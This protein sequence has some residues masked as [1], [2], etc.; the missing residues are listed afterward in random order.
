MICPMCGRKNLEI[1]PVDDYES[2]KMS[3]GHMPVQI[4]APNIRLLRY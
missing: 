4:V 3:V 1:I 2:Y